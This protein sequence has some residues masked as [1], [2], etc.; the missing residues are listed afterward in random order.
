MDEEPILRVASPFKGSQNL[1]QVIY[2]SPHS[3]AN[4]YIEDC[5]FRAILLEPSL[6]VYIV[7]LSAVQCFYLDSM[8]ILLMAPHM[9]TGFK[10]LVHIGGKRMLPRDKCCQRCL[11][12]S[13]QAMMVL[14]V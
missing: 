14:E 2:C 8:H 9:D 11:Y 13:D 3:C 6:Q 4:I 10:V 12:C 1:V 7:Y 5:R